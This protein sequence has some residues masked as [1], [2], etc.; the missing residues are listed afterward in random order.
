MGPYE[1]LGIARGASADEVKAAY[2]AACLEHHP[3]LAPPQQRQQAE[4]RFRAAVEAYHRLQPGSRYSSQPSYSARRHAA[5]RPSRR[6]EWA[7]APRVR[8]S[9]TMLATAISV[10][11]LLV[12][13]YIASVSEHTPQDTGR[14]HGLLQPPVNP[15]L[16][17]RFKPRTH[18]SS[19]AVFRNRRADAEG[20]PK[21][22]ESQQSPTSG[23]S[24]AAA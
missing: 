5:G 24:P 8:L 14:P 12:G 1:V 18:A 11:L 17:E 23:S 13:V 6:Y 21:L 22:D 20:A 2:R 7:T 9:N 15:Y 19:L 10:P 16:A 4:T 3:D